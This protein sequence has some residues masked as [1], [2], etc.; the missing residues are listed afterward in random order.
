MVDK[1]IPREDPDD[2]KIEFDEDARLDDDVDFDPAGEPA[3]LEDE[4]VR[5]D[6]ADNQ[7]VIEDDDEPE[8]YHYAD[9]ADDDPDDSTDADDDPDE[10]ADDWREK[11]AA[12]ER[13]AN[14]AEAQ[15]ILQQGEAQ[16]RQIVA[17]RNTA[18]AVLDNL[19]QRRSQAQEA[20]VAARNNDDASAELQA[21]K[22]LNDIDALERQ[23][24]QAVANLEDENKVFSEARAKAAAAYNRPVQGAD[25]GV[26]IQARNTLAER[27]ASANP[28][29]K[30]QRHAKAND[31]V[32][33]QSERMVADGYDPNSRTFYRELTE[34]VNRQ[35]P[36]VKA[37]VSNNAKRRPAKPGERRR[38]P[39]ASSR[40][41]T[42]MPRPESQ[43]GRTIRFTNQM[44][45]K[46]ESLNLDPR[47]EQ[48]R[49]HYARTIRD[50]NRA[51]A[52]RQ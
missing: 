10:P 36:R 50:L 22:L 8:P 32:I 31:F 23:A 12:A 19:E 25:V 39:V 16:A 49:K 6:R 2:I 1:T 28:W 29:M 20:F 11:A 40:S 5:V 33:K 47:N 7:T 38:T 4:P 21:Q 18:K 37:Q 51:D 26:G 35:F 30:E 52:R 44:L 14:M 13:R 9:E 48:H 46:M 15:R 27:W 24:R 42:G 45:R 41:Q 17:D 34:R 3:E 43:T